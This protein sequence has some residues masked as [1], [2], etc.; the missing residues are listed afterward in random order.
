M[1]EHSPTALARQWS[2]ATSVVAD[3]EQKLN[4]ALTTQHS[5]DKA[6]MREMPHGQMRVLV[7]Q[8]NLFMT[9]VD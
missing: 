8:H 9:S 5:R 6:S 2:K 1:V 4:K 3:T 7:R